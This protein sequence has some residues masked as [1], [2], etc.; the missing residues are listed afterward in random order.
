METKEFKKKKYAPVN[1]MRTYLF[2]LFTLVLLIHTGCSDD[3]DKVVYTVTFEADGGSPVPS[4]QKVEAGSMATAPA[5]NPTKAGYAFVFWYA[6]SNTTAYNFQTPVNSDITL[7]AKWQEEAVAEYW[8]VSWN[9]NG[10]AWPS[11]DNHATKV[12]KGGTLAEPAAPTKSGYKFDGWYKE[13]ALSNKISFPYYVSSVTGHFTLYAKWATEGASTDP[14]GYRMFT[15]VSSLSSWLSSQS[16]NSAE[17]AY[18]IGLK[19]VN[20]NSGNN[21]GDLGL[22]IGKTNKTKFVDVNLQGCSATNIPDGYYEGNLSV[23]VY[24]GVFLDCANLVA[25]SLPKGIKF[26]GKYAFWGCK[27][28][29]SVLMPEGL[30][31]IHQESFRD[32]LLLH[33]I[34]FPETITSIE[35]YAFSNCNKL[36][37]FIFPKNLKSLGQ[38]AF[39]SCGLTTLTIPSSMANLEWG[40]TSVFANNNHLTT[41]VIEEGIKAITTS[42]FADCKLLESVTLPQ[43]FKTISQAMFKSCKALKTLEIPANVTSIEG[44]AFENAFVT[45]YDGKAVATLILRPATPPTLGWKPFQ[46]TGSLVIKV[47]A[48]SLNTYKAAWSEYA[49]LI[50]ANTN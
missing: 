29:Q 1:R 16:A 6:S 39:Q 2:M 11:G 5:T 37:S 23:R 30:T 33:S 10:G 50:V 8:Q 36:S 27:N 35:S 41:V 49:S 48:A 12:I 19:D 20:L 9:L 17:T 4:A 45:S 25:I 44:S 40:S 7:Y 28:L 47:P 32:C 18:K 31:E 43:S 34:N 14:T 42:A 46:Y 26:I 22:A 24:Y 21:W 38:N 13:S 3:G 15:S